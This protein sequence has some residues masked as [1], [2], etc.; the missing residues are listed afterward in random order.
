V[1]RVDVWGDDHPGHLQEQFESRPSPQRSERAWEAPELHPERAVHH[2][3][4]LLRL[5]PSM[6]L[7]TEVR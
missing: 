5:R 3:L 4:R 2:R 7:A 1:S 6:T